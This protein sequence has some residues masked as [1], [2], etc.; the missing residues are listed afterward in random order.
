MSEYIE[1]EIEELDNPR[2]LQI[3]TNLQLSE[4]AIEI[5]NS[6][7]GMEEGSPVAQILAYIEGI[8]Q[9][10]LANQ[11]MTITRHPDTPWHIIVAEVSAIIKEFFL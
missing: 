6:P 8:E 5:Y 1:I 4:D 10:Q 11:T 2:L 3:H 9:L 7:A